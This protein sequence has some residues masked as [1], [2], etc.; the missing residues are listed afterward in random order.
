MFPRRTTHVVPA[1]PSEQISF[2]M[3]SSRLPFM[4]Y[5]PLLGWHII[6]AEYIQLNEHT[7]FV[8]PRSYP[9]KLQHFDWFSVFYS[10]EC[11]TARLNYRCVTSMAMLSYSYVCVF[12]GPSSQAALSYQ[13]CLRN[14]Y[15]FFKNH[16]KCPLLHWRLCSLIAWCTFYMSYFTHL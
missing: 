12:K 5:R 6:G 3:L 11:S 7:T 13:F 10:N 8:H 16:L 14:H 4:R 2:Q 1:L 9:P 15:W